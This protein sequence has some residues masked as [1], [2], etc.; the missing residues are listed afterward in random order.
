M[1]KSKNLKDSAFL[2]G[3]E[4][5]IEEDIDFLIEIGKL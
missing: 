1:G 3:I 5:Q 2:K 4:K